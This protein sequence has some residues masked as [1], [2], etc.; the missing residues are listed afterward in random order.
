MTKGSNPGPINTT[1]PFYLCKSLHRQ[2]DK[3]EAAARVPIT[4][5]AHEAQC[6]ASVTAGGSAPVG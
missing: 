4:M 1:N 5:Y 3:G 6:A 2:L